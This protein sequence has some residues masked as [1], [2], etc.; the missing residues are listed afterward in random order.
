MKQGR[1]LREI[2][3]RDYGLEVERDRGKGI[4]V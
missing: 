1:S 3:L 2:G 4:R